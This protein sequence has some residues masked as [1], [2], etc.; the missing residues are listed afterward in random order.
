MPSKSFIKII[1][2]LLLLSLGPASIYIMYTRTGGLES[3]R[4]LAFHK[5][6]RFAFMA[7]TDAVPLATLTDWPWETV[8]AFGPGLSQADLDELIGFSYENFAQ[9]TWRD[10]EDHWT[11]LFIDRERET[12]WGMHRPVIPIRVPVIDIAGYNGLRSGECV[13]SPSAQLALSRNEFELGVS[14]VSAA[15]VPSVPN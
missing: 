6:A 9:M 8:C 13:T 10:L 12:N 15:L 5:N 14:P 7:G 1:G 4:E 3:R 11:L 2:L